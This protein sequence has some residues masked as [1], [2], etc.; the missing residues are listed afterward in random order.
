M[1]NIESRPQDREVDDRMVIAGHSVFHQQG[2]IYQQVEM[3]SMKPLRDMG[4]IKWR[5]IWPAVFTAE[6]FWGLVRR[7]QCK[8]ARAKGP[9]AL[10]R[11]K[12]QCGQGVPLSE[13]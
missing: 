2:E 4:K 6:R 9:S 1:R 11:P 7:D 10:G 5:A 3:L 13:S 12:R 8:L